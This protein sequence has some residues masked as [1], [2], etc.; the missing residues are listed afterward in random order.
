[1]NLTLQPLNWR[2]PTNCFRFKIEKMWQQH[3]NTTFSKTSKEDFEEKG[4]VELI[5][6]SAVKIISYS[7]QVRI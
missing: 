1:M 6:I 7:I 2:N 4:H 5:F 3:W